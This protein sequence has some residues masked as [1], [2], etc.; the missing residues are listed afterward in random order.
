MKIVSDC[1]NFV[2]TM[3]SYIK[4]K[5]YMSISQGRRQNFGS[6]GRRNTEQNFIHEILSSPAV[7]QWRSQNLG[8]IMYSSKTFEKFRKINKKLAQKLKKFPKFFKK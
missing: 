8:D 4:F 5:N 1:F 2:T 7:L 6:G 3:L